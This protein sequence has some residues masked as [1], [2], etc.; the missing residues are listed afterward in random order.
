MPIKTHSVADTV[1]KDFK[2]AAVR[3]HVKERGVAFV[4]FLTHVARR[5]HRNV[6]QAVRPEANKL[7]TMHTITWE[8]LI[9]DHRLRRSREMFL[10]LVETKDAMD[11]SNIECA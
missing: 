8:V 9:H 4:V 6:K 7:P 11:L 2:S 10:N 3:L 1:G 5:S